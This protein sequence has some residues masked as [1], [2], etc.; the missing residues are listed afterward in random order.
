M[1][2]SSGNRIVIGL[3]GSFGSGCSTLG[4]GLAGAGFKVISLSKI[5]HDIWEERNPDKPPESAPR[6]ELQ[7]IGN[8]LRREKGNSYL[9]DIAL[10]EVASPRVEEDKLVFD[11]IRHTEEVEVF[12]R[13]FPDFILITVI[14][15]LDERWA[16]LSGKYESQH[17][18]R[19]DF[20]EDDERDTN[21]DISYG[22]QVR[23]CVDNADIAITSDKHFAPEHARKSELRKKAEPL[24]RL[25]TGEDVRPPS[26]WEYM[27]VAAYAQALSSKCYK[28]QVGA[29]IHDEN[30]IVLGVGCNHNPS[31]LDPCH[32]QY[33]ECY[34]D[35]YKR[36]LFEDLKKN[37]HCPKCGL[38]LNGNLSADYKCK[39]KD[40]GFDVDRYYV[41][42][43]ALSR[44]TALHAEEAAIIN[45][46]GKNLE[47][48][49]MYTTTFPCFL[50]VQR[51]IGSGI[52]E[53]VY[54]EPYPD[55]DAAIL[56]QDVNER[57]RNLGQQ[58]IKVYPFE[59]I[60]ARAY[61]RVFGGWRRQQEK[62]IDEKRRMA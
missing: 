12:R 58:E 3:T 7:S 54:C 62:I 39:G 26:P 59:G 24:I 22:Q 40:C 34:R 4:D 6:R 16:R 47:G 43:R 45:A 48:C 10:K 46:G 50:C 18:T 15:S 61:F 9:A 20:L 33:G 32:S 5:V 44:C 27:M 35:I 30:G 38:P 53:V 52:K 8:E 42:D 41:R 60:K 13:S 19:R 1:S 17:L 31:P 21:E 2:K 51:I 56:I 29:L 49:S 11:S 23:L 37:A 25:L 55:P 14:S 28:R 36:E 57:F